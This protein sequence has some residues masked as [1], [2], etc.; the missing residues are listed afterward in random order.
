MSNVYIYIGII[1]IIIIKKT[2]QT[3]QTTPLMTKKKPTPE[4][5]QVV[6]LVTQYGSNK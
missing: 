4:P 6:I 5:H 2:R 1:I 3:L